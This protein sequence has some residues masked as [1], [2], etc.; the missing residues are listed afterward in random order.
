MYYGSHKL[1]TEFS[2]MTRARNPPRHTFQQNH[3]FFFLSFNEN[4]I[5]KCFKVIFPEQTLFPKY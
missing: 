5:L 1:N 3:H 4:N 2:F